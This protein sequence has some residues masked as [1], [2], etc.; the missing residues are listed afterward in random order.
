MFGWAQRMAFCSS[1][2]MAGAALAA[3]PHFRVEGDAIALVQDAERFSAFARDV[4]SIV[5][6]SLQR[7]SEPAGEKLLLG[8]RL[9][10]A[11]HFRKDELALR[12]AE[13]IRASQ[14]DPLLLSSTEIS[15]PF[16]DFRFIAP[17]RR[18]RRYGFNAHAL[19][20]HL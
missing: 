18:R 10:L 8:L 6:A 19:I 1:V 14:T 11:L 5:D 7:T 13:R 16:A 3:S 20:T 15:T 17:H 2:L 9:H 4:A 12:L